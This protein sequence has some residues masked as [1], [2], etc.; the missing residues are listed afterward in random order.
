MCA[1]IAPVDSTSTPGG[2]A[3]RAVLNFAPP[4]ATPATATLTLVK[5][6]LER[7]AGEFRIL[8]YQAGGIVV[9]EQTYTQAVVVSPQIAPQAWAIGS[10]H[11]MDGSSLEALLAH[12]PEVI[13]IGT[14]RKQ[15]FPDMRL[16]AS[17]YERHIGLEVM[18]TAA[19]CRTFNI[20]AGEGRRVV[21]GLI[22]F[23]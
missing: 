15:V 5:L 2:A 21:A 11:E 9:N 17:M 4:R 13:L 7:A 23:D 10:I 3:P 14:G 20:I 8:G 1:W 22:P 16:L 12:E 6:H 19:A 18:D